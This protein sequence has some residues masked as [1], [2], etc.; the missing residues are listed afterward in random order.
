VGDFPLAEFSIAFFQ[1]VVPLQADPARDM[2]EA[3]VARDESKS[4][5]GR[6]WCQARM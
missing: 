2:I 4:M 5:G 6:V 1:N 3:L